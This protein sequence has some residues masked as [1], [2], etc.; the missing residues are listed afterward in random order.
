MLRDVVGLRMLWELGRVVFLWNPAAVG[1][2]VPIQKRMVSGLSTYIYIY[3]YIGM[4]V[5]WH[6]SS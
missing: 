2:N 1:S 3:I 4:E 5:G 6:R